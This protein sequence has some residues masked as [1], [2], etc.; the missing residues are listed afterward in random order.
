MPSPLLTPAA[1]PAWRGLPGPVYG[2]SPRHARR[3]AC[4]GA[5]PHRLR[6]GEAGGTE[7]IAIATVQADEARPHLERALRRVA[8]PAA[9]GP[10]QPSVRGGWTFLSL[11][12]PTPAAAAAV[13]AA[14][15]EGLCDFILDGC[16]QRLLRR[17][18]AARY[19]YFTPAEQAEIVA[20]AERALAARDRR[21]GVRS[22]LLQYLQG[23]NTLIVEGFLTFRLKDLVGEAEEA[24]DGAVDAFL[25]QREYREFIRLLRHFVE[26]LPP[27]HDLVHAVLQPGGGFRLADADGSPL[28]ADPAAGGAAADG[29]LAPEDRVISALVTLAP[30]AIVLHRPAGPAALSEEALATVREV[31]GTRLHVCAGCRICRGE[32]PVR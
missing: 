11:P 18:V 21:E 8:G 7:T 4:P 13:R 2:L 24:L 12:V 17:L 3:A 32:A 25:L 30:R 5:Q 6:A 26:T 10:L 1:G 9:P 19:S 16:R 14:L 22:R 31:F 27:R 29:E 15:A 28:P 23:Q 20:T